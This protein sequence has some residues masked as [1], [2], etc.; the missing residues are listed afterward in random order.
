[1]HSIVQ[2]ARHS[3]RGVTL[4]AASFSGRL[5]SAPMVLSLPNPGQR[6]SLLYTIRGRHRPACPA[7]SGGQSAKTAPRLP[8]SPARC[9]RRR[10]RQR[11]GE[12][13]RVT[14]SSLT[15]APCRASPQVALHVSKHARKS[16]RTRNLPGCDG[17]LKTTLGMVPRS[18]AFRAAPI[19]AP[20]ILPHK[21]RVYAAFAPLTPLHP[22]L[23]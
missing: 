6:P 12:L 15:T 11:A 7:W 23:I 5:E 16:C 4:C 13:V 3:K 18:P 1:M 8:I 22:G 14:L 17:G 9:R 21:P 19:G 20:A 10:R 2:P